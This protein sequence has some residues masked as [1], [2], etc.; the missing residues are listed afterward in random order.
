MVPGRRESELAVRG[1]DDIR[2]KMIMTTKD[3]FG[4]AIR[5]LV[6]SELPND[7]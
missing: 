4:V 3:A 1:D 5:I 6:T 2:D 7:N